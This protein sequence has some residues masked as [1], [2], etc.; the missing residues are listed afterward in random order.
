[1][2][3][4]SEPNIEKKATAASTPPIKQITP[5]IRMTVPTLGVISAGMTLTGMSDFPSSGC[6]E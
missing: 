2:A 4:D 1:V 6:S 3:L 5:Q